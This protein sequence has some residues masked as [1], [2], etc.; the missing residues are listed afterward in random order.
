MQGK[1]AQ[2]WREL[3]NLWSHAMVSKPWDEIYAV[4]GLCGF[5]YPS[6]SMQFL[7]WSEGFQLELHKFWE[8]AQWWAALRSFLGEGNLPAL[9]NFGGLCWLSG[10]T[11]K[12]PRARLVSLQRC[13]VFQVSTRTGLRPSRRRLACRWNENK[14]ANSSCYAK[15]TQ[16]KA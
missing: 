2:S 5:S 15:E 7:D 6:S 9:H 3:V 14:L 13:T 12:F 8:K 11:M 10:C 4:S 1:I 16:L